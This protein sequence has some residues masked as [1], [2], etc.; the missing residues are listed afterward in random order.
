MLG[1][2]FSK[3]NGGGT[4]CSDIREHSDIR[5]NNGVYHPKGKFL[6]E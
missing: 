6:I 3:K 4:P 5:E 2:Y 1:G